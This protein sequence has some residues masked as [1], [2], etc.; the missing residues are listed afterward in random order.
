MKEEVEG[1][2]HILYDVAKLNRHHFIE[3]Q[4]LRKIDQ[5][6]QI[7]KTQNSS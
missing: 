7:R 2:H 5:N 6:M 4:I 1:N 3:D